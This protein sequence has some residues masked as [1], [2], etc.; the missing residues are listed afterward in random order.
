M[1]WFNACVREMVIDLVFNFFQLKTGLRTF[2]NSLGWLGS[3]AA[4]DLGP[5]V[6]G[7]VADDPSSTLIISISLPIF[8][9][10]LLEPFSFAE[11]KEFVY[12]ASINSPK[13]VPE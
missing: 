8:P 3:K 9:S 7:R 4:N 12:G 6:I 5:K 10:M 13:I 1:D 11:F 2:Y